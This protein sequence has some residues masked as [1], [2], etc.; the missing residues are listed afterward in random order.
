MGT[1]GPLESESFF[2][3]HAGMHGM[4]PFS[5]KA[6]TRRMPSTGLVI[7]VRPLW[8]PTKQTDP[9]RACARGVVGVVINRDGCRAHP[10]ALLRRSRRKPLPANAV[11]R[12]RDMRPASMAAH[13]TNRSTAS[14]VLLLIVVMPHVAW[15]ELTLRFIHPD[16][17]PVSIAGAGLCQWAFRWARRPGPVLEEEVER[18]REQGVRLVRTY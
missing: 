13:E 7:C 3:A 8:Q 12:P 15:E 6:V 9:Q 5:A 4:Q 18:G 10:W 17:L 16:Q 2:L 1:P 11:H 14:L